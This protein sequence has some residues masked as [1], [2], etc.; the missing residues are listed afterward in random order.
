MRVKTPCSQSSYAKVSESGNPGCAVP[1]FRTA[2][3][4][5]EFRT[6]RTLAV[7]RVLCYD[8]HSTGRG[9]RTTIPA[10]M[11]AADTTA[12]ERKRC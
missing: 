8:Y 12:F 6:S 3:A 10:A 9:R 4:W 2:C 1:A 5:E 7:C 11:R